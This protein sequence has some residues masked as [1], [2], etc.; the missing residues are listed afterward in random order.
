MGA[1]ERK[2]SSI[3][4]IGFPDVEIRFDH[5]VGE[6]ISGFIISNK[7]L[8][9]DHEARQN[10]VW[11]LLRNKLSQQERQEILGFLIYTPEEL[12]VYSEAYDD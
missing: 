7:F 9:M 8:N 2:I 5:E 6:R 4:N 1:T 3:L 12:K 10:A 11:S